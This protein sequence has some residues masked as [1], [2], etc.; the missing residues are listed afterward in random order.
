M[1]FTVALVTVVLFC[2]K[3]ERIKKW[4]TYLNLVKFENVINI[5][6]AEIK[7]KGICDVDI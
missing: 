2:F 3:L 6:K 4:K 7:I 5:G 1:Y